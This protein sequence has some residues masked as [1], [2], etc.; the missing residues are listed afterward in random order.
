MRADDLVI[1]SGVIEGAIRNLVRL[2]LDG[3][4]MWWGRQRSERVLHLRCV[5]LNRQWPDFVKP[6]AGVGHLRL[7]GEPARAQTHD[8]KAA[9]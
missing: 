8:A 4:G 6:R 2:R 1:G 5:L 3:P 7:P 9:A